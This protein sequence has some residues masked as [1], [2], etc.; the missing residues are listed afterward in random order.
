MDNL[1]DGFNPGG[2]G[3]APRIGPEAMTVARDHLN[4]ARHA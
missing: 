1:L 4:G 3:P 2:P